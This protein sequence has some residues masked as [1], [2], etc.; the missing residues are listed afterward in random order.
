MLCAAL[1]TLRHELFFDPNPDLELHTE[2]LHTDL[3]DLQKIGVAGAG[4]HRLD[5]E[6]LVEGHWNG[7]ETTALAAG[8][9]WHARRTYRP[10][11]IDTW[12]R[13][14][15]AGV[16]HR[17]M[18]RLELVSELD[19]AWLTGEPVDQQAGEPL[20]DNAHLRWTGELAWELNDRARMALGHSRVDYKDELDPGAEQDYAAG[21]TYLKLMGRF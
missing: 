7:D 6:L 2:Y 5:N 11:K 18:P 9:T 17:F 10:E 1:V 21:R 14:I 13:R 15:F 12:T 19:Y 4:R 16:T 8:F 3:Q 20:V